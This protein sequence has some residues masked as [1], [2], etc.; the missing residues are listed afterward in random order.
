MILLDTNI[1]IEMV[2]FCNIVEKSVSLPKIKMDMDKERIETIVKQLTS[3]ER[4]YFIDLLNEYT[5]KDN[6]RSV[7]N[8]VS[9]NRRVECPNCCSTAV[10]GHGKYRGRSRYQCKT[11]RKTFNDNT[12]TA[13]SGI[14][15][16]SEF[17]SYLQLLID[18]VSIRKAA[19]KLDLNVFT[20]FTWRHKLLSAI[21]MKNGSLFSDIIV[22]CDDKQLNISEKGNKH[23][24][25][26]S[27]K[28]PSDRNTKRGVSN[29]K[30]SVVVA[31][32]RTNNITMKVA[33]QG[34]LDTKSIDESIGSFVQKSNIFCTDSHPSIISWASS[35]GLE[36]H[37]FVASKQHVKDK[38]FH[39]QYVDYVNNRFE[40]WQKQF[41]GIATKYLQNYLNWFVFL[42]RIKTSY[43]KYSEL[44][45]T[46]FANINAIADFRNIHAKYEKLIRLQYNKT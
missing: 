40:H 18:S 43:D 4:V 7:A 41:Y 29:D 39:V 11:C 38:C 10:Y 26:K 1:L 8:T 27:Y 20:V 28:R 32:D 34:R 44:L 24:E 37:R 13:I 23:L 25:R 14:K 35:R 5:R 2:I 31:T 22:E 12:G 9:Q 33:K 19:K 16:V 3:S 36:H 30:I 46:M 15:K 17:Q 21:A 6:V 42:E 45:K